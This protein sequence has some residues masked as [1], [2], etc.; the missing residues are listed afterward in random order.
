MSIDAP[1][2]KNSFSYEDLLLCGHGELFGPGNARL[3][4]PPLL[5]FDRFISMIINGVIFIVL[6]KQLEEEKVRLVIY[7]KE[8][9]MNE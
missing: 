7:Q 9:H 3:P 5:M 2:S 4:L 8:D 1:F 6:E